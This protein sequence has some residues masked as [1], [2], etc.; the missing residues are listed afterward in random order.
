MQ[1]P[2]LSRPN[3]PAALRGA[4]HALKA[5]GP[6]RNRDAAGQLGVSEAELIASECG[7]GVTRLD[8]DFRELMKRVPQLGRVMALTRNE[9]C[10]HER[11]G[12]Y[13]DV[14]ASGHVGLVLGPDIDL[15][16]FYA[17]WTFG[18]AVREALKDGP[19]HSLQ[20]YDAAGTAIHKI[21]LLK[22]SHA[23]AFEE[24]VAAFR[25]ARQTPGEA[26]TP[27]EPEAAERPDAEI[28]QQG[29]REAWAAMKDT[30]EFFGILRKHKATRTQALRLA[31]PR[32]AKPLRPSVVRELLETV[33]RSAL[34]IMVFVGNPGNIQ[35]HTGPVTK[36]KVMGPWLNVLDPDFNLHLREDHVDSVWLVRKPTTDGIVT[37]V[38]LFDPAGRNIALI[39]GKRKPGIP[40][41]EDWRATV[42]G[43]E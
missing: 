10:V 11:K 43:L 4:W 15:R 31:E 32:F 17:H 42:A 9:S 28:D 37:S 2:T 8:G 29:L 5:R 39:F 23:A 40:E 18:Y 1:T 21:Y 7:E 12:A 38:E 26:V 36:V 41:S 35:I 27:T 16:V 24:I 22:E 3:D 25:A 30:H 20:F 6:V 19:R 13:E 34:P 14:S 33:S